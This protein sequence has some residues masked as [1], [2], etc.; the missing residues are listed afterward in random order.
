MV[1]TV[2]LG[3]LI[4]PEMIFLA[5]FRHIKLYCSAKV[6]FQRIRI[7]KLPFTSVFLR[8]RRAGPTESYTGPQVALEHMTITRIIGCSLLSKFAR[9]SQK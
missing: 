7:T 3:G 2:Q 8:I 6:E 4:K 1:Q 5:I 9:I